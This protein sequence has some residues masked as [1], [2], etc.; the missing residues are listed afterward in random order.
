MEGRYNEVLLYRLSV[1]ANSHQCMQIDDNIQSVAFFL[2]RNN[3][4]FD[5]LLLVI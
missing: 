3:N 5:G 2:N 4:F 1:S